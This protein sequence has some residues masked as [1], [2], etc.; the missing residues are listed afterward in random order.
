MPGLVSIPF[1][2]TPR[3]PALRWPL[4]STAGSLSGD[5]GLKPVLVLAVEVREIPNV[6]FLIA[7]ERSTGSMDF[8]DVN[9]GEG[10]D[11]QP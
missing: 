10:A 2:M 8:D 1:S 9:L 4:V 5:V 11:L 3:L 6:G 7:M